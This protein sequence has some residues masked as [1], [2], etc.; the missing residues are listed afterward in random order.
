LDDRESNAPPLVRFIEKNGFSYSSYIF[1]NETEIEHESRFYGARL[2]AY[3]CLLAHE[4]ANPFL[5]REIMYIRL[6]EASLECEE[7]SFQ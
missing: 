4:V 6:M 1:E 3:M 7:R 2:P 5:V